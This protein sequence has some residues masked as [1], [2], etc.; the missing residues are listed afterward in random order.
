ML[1][2]ILMAYEKAV[3]IFSLFFSFSIYKNDE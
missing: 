2:L 1:K 3:K